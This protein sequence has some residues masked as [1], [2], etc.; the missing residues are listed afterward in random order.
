MTP[1]EISN[2]SESLRRHEFVV[3]TPDAVHVHVVQEVVNTQRGHVA[4]LRSKTEVPL[5]ECS[6]HDFYA[7]AMLFPE[8]D[9][10]E[11]PA[12]P[13]AAPA[14]YTGPEICRPGCSCVFEPGDDI[15]CPCHG[16][17]GDHPAPPVLIRKEA[18]WPK[19]ELTTEELLT[20]GR[21]G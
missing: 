20:G 21:H 2:L 13:A 1:A 3:Y 4:R 18:T 8:P 16:W 9:A 7:A 19:A 10:T 5:D 11:Q 6:P 15:K 12:P 14:E 17:H